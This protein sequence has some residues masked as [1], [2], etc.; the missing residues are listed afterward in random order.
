MSSDYC[1]LLTTCGN[2]EQAEKIART[3][4]DVRLAACIQMLPITS[5]YRWQG[6]V[7][8]DPE[9]LLFIKTRTAVSEQAQDQIR[10]VHDYDV[11][12]IVQIPIDAGLPDYLD[13]IGQET[14]ATAWS[15]HY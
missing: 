15:K 6:E 14:V 12:E 11:P 4:L 7:A 1:I 8:N 2:S 10:Q 13:W 3:L 5:W 9:Q